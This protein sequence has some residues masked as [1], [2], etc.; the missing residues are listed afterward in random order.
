MG[1]V[2]DDVK[3]INSVYKPRAFK[4][5]IVA[6]QFRIRM[7]GTQNSLDSQPDWNTIIYEHKV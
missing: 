3:D 1:W 7:S 5:W 6:I 4:M 2:M